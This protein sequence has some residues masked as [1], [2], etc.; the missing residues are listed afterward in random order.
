MRYLLLLLLSG[1]M[2]QAKIDSIVA[3]CPQY[4][5]DNVGDI[6]YMPVSWGTV[7]LI[8]GVTDKHTGEIWLTA[9]AGKHTVLHEIGHSVYFRTPHAAFDA[10]FRVNRGFVSFWSLNHPEAVAEAFYEGMK[11]GSNPRIDCA[12][13]FFEKGE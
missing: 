1:C 8:S 4:V 6:R 9:W 2:S 7:M 11:G 12:M 3:T 13:N 10:E 5:Q